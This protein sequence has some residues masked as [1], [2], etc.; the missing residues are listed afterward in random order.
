[1]LFYIFALLRAKL[2]RVFYISKFWSS[3]NKEMLTFP[4]LSRDKIRPKVKLSN[5]K[6]VKERRCYFAA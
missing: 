4:L 1:M 2:R 3:E 6:L 5:Q